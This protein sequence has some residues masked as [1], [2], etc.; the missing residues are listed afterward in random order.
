MATARAAIRERFA[1]PGSLAEVVGDLNRS[2]LDDFST[3]DR[4]MTLFA[5][6]IDRHDGHLCWVRAGHDPALVYYK[7]EDRFDTL[8]GAGLPLGISGRGGFTEN[9]ADVLTPGTV[10][11]VGTDG[12][13]EARGPG[14]VMFGKERFKEIIRRE[15][16]R[17]AR[18]ILD[19]V[20]Q[21]LYRFSSGYKP[22]DDITLVIIKVENLAA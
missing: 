20:Y 14:D 9:H 3:T 17:S 1:S 12:I 8:D 6:Q 22:E 15:S 21:D 11:A 18:E 10:I 2:L 7:D 19:T 4:F 5:L 16:S 13:W